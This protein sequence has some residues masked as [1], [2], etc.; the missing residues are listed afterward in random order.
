MNDKMISNL[1]TPSEY[2]KEMADQETGNDELEPHQL[3]LPMEVRVMS[4][5]EVIALFNMQQ[6]EINE[7]SKKLDEVWAIVDR[8]WGAR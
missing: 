8:V 1:F 3:A 2:L 7:L 5:I 6:K 4:E